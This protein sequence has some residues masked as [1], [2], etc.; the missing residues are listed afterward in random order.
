MA[1]KKKSTVK[2]KTTAKKKT[3][4]KKKTA[5]TKKTTAR[6]KTAV[7]KTSARKK[8]TAK[9]KAS[10]GKTRPPAPAPLPIEWSTVYELEVVKRARAWNRARDVD[11]I[12]GINRRLAFGG[13]DDVV[14]DADRAYDAAI[15]KIAGE[16]L[17][18][19]NRI[20]L[21]I[22]AGPSSSGKTTTTIKLCRAL[23]TMGENLQLLALDNYFW[24]LK[25]QPVDEFGNVKFE[26]PDALDTAT[27]NENLKDLLSGQEAK[28]PIYDFKAGRRKKEKLSMRL[29]EGQLLVVE[30]LHGFHQSLTEGIPKDMQFR[31]YIESVCQLRDREDNFVPWTDIRLLR[32]MVRDNKHRN[33]PPL[34]TLAHWHLVREA[35]KKYIVPYI[36]MSDAVV[37]GYLPYELPVYKKYLY[38][39]LKEAVDHFDDKEG[40][41]DAL[42]RG[43]RCLAYLEEV[44]ALEDDSIIPPTSLIREFI[45]GSVYEY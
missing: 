38:D 37:N 17:G 12:A 39:A 4:V 41:A 18:N 42:R 36:R 10:S 20:R 33:Y 11:T 6:K 45:G 2:K 16:I 19:R 14:R 13:Y 23:R 40:G 27:I 35:E 9:K 26:T 7:K 30:G 25:D 5:A 21:V 15:W 1:P 29:E 44:D 3:A 22:V 31:V 34:K 32:R 24:N 8:T 43:E 28:L